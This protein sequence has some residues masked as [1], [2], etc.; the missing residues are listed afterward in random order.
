MR[1]GILCLLIALLVISLEAA[2]PDLRA[3]DVN[4]QLKEMT[5]AHALH[6]KLDEPIIQRALSNYIDLLDPSKLYFLKSE[7]DMWVDAP[8]AT[9]AKVLRGYK[10]HD[11]LTYQTISDQMDTAIAR[12]NALEEEIAGLPLPQGVNS[13][14]F[15]NLDYAA[16]SDELKERLL[17]LRGYQAELAGSLYDE[18]EVAIALLNKRRQRREREMLGQTPEEREKMLYANVLKATA[19]ALDSQTAYFTPDEAA[20]F[21][22]DLQQRLF[23]IGVQMRDNLN[24]FTVVRV[25][26]GG[27]AYNEGTLRSDDLIVAVNGESVMGLDIQDTVQRI[28]GPV[29]SPVILTV[30]R[31]DR[32]RDVSINRGEVVIT[33]QRIETSYAPYGDGVIGRIALYSFYQDENNSSA[34]DINDAINALKAQH[35]V[36]GIVLDLRRNTGGLLPQAIAVTGLFITKGVVASIRDND[37]NVQF[38][39]DSGGY[40]AWDGPLVVLTSRLSAS[41]SEIVAGA[42]QDYGRALIVGDET[43]YGKGTF[44][45]STIDLGG[46]TVN[47]KGE[48]K[49]TRGTYFTVSGKSP[50]L[51]GVK[52][53]V[54]APSV[55][56]ELELGER[57]SK[58]PL[59]PDSIPPNFEDDLS[60]IPRRY[61]AHVKK[62][63]HFDLQQQTTAYTR[64]LPQL[65]RNSA[66]RVASSAEYQQFLVALKEGNTTVTDE[67][68]DVQLDEAYDVMR[69]L[70]ILLDNNRVQ[71]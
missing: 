42:L 31:G 27:P 51:T 53:D 4:K 71:Q 54:I 39:R 7:V 50:Q 62:T 46:G 37:G 35:N 49:V 69:D 30:M 8:P 22:M 21:V 2:P 45:T 40:V 56:S 28:R 14:E 43:T 36:K 55:F 65:Q 11:Y 6:K 19:S 64:F 12:R 3:D 32:Y 61:R 60:D 44:Q 17:R 25:I 66:Q 48:Y 9:V 38:L 41:A 1:K 67:A 33:E 68:G 15:K 16:N 23:G 29:G 24:G 26:E 13:D 5:R 59:E 10:S 20:S 58:Y 52:A 18:P 63:Y 34:S 47:P 70:I 57:F